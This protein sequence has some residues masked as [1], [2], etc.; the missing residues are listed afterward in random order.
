VLPSM[1]KPLE[2]VCVC[3]CVVG[4]CVRAYA[5]G[6]ITLESTGLPS[7]YTLWLNSENV[8]IL[9]RLFLRSLWRD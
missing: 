2:E 3:V 4:A 6:L 5:R 8:L 9:L 1:A 7:T